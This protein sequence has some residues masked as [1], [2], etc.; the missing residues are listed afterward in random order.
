MQIN[1]ILRLPFRIKICIVWCDYRVFF[2]TFSPIMYSSLCTYISQK[3]LVFSKLWP[4]QFKKCLNFVKVTWERIKPGLTER[5]LA[6]TLYQC[7][8]VRLMVMSRQRK[9]QPKYI[10]LKTM[11]F[12]TNTFKNVRILHR[13][14]GMWICHSN[15]K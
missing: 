1:N 12:F 8:C 4:I 3:T 13:L 7:C 14:H 5:L 15:R 2:E 9:I 10:V 6:F 11:I